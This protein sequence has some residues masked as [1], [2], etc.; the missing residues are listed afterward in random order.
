M[1]SSN[2]NSTCRDADLV[3]TC[4]GDSTCKYSSEEC[5][6]TSL[7]GC[8]EA[9]G[10]ELSQAVC[11]VWND[12]REC[13]ELIGVYAYTPNWKED[14]SACGVEENNW[15]ATGSAYA[16]RYALCAS[17]IPLIQS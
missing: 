17:K 12:P 2:V 4:V 1:T 7:T 6:V 8:G 3:N 14:G 11:K 10:N 9:M 16:N 5:E 15:C 13:S